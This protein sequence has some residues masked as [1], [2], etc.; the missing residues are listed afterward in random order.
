[1]GDTVVPGSIAELKAKQLAKKTPVAESAPTSN[2][3][4]ALKAKQLGAKEVLPIARETA[5][6]PTDG[7]IGWLEGM[8]GGAFEGGDPASLASGGVS[9]PAAT[10][11]RQTPSGVGQSVMGALTGAVDAGTM[12]LAPHVM[13]H[14]LGGLAGLLTAPLSVAKTVAGA[15][16]PRYDANRAQMDAAEKAAP[17]AN[18]VGQMAGYVATG[19]GMGK[20]GAA[21]AGKSPTIAKIAD[22]I[23]GRIAGGGIQGATQAGTEALVR[24]KDP[25][26]PAVLGAAGGA[27]GQAVLGELV[28]NVARA[29]MESDAP[30]IAARRIAQIYQKA[31]GS[32]GTAQ[33]M[34][35]DIAAAGKGAT[36]ADATG[37]PPLASELM[38]GSHSAQADPLKDTLLKR[39]TPGTDLLTDLGKG[40]ETAIP[41]FSHQYQAPAFL[42]SPTSP[43]LGSKTPAQLGEVIKERTRSLQPQYD[44]VL[45]VAPTY[46]AKA[47]IK[48]ALAASLV[49]NGAEAASAGVA[50]AYKAVSKEVDRLSKGAPLTPAQVRALLTT[51]R[52]KSYA[53]TKKMG[54][55]GALI[56]GRLSGAAH[57]VEAATLD[58]LPGYSQLN[59]AY[60]EAVDYSS[61]HDIG[62]NLMKMTVDDLST[63]GKQITAMSNANY[64]GFLDGL[65]KSI[66]TKLQP[67]TI[68]KAVA[69]RNPAKVAR[70]LVD[71]DAVRSVLQTVLPSATAD[72]VL[73]LANAAV[74]QM[75][76][77]KTALSATAAK[78]VGK[79]AG[80]HSK[81]MVDR[82]I[83]TLF[84]SKMFDAARGL[85]PIQPSSASAL[86]VLG[87][88]VGSHELGPKATQLA[89]QALNTTGSDVAN[90]VNSIFSQG[91]VPNN[92]PKSIFDKL[93]EFSSPLRRGVAAT[94]TGA[95]AANFMEQKQ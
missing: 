33:G 85:K 77:A 37:M 81:K 32:T 1:M 58:N 65:T 43:Y 26:L 18:M 92:M 41:Q 55:E 25:T 9:M 60:K 4:A 19:T 46:I 91:T 38:F 87:R 56:R 10:G 78:E 6:P 82:G 36:V 89:A 34:M 12:G 62:W 3:V 29:V 22:S 51:I 88:T 40:A 93:T 86:G 5:K 72:E 13:N 67:A 2:S 57:A 70:D 54:G 73:G 17:I 66:S 63:V 27:A 44:S 24:G 61:A 74:K 16:N 21:A 7:F 50:A 35:D 47:D 71:N 23:F 53:M 52:E 90:V 8:M 15:D 42:S 11:E 76:T 94:A 39:V 80:E 69:V 68:A 48:K 30:Q 83:I 28:P 59:A 45:N 64:S 95:G 20:L 14:P 31:K 49:P 75:A 79:Q 84:F